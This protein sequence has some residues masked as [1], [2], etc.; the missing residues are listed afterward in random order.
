MITKNSNGKDSSR[1]N[2]IRNTV[3]I[4]AGIAV[5]SLGSTSVL[6]QQSDTIAGSLSDK[7]KKFMALFDLKY[8]I[9]QAPTAGPAG[10]ALA[11]AVANAGAM[12]CLPLS[13]D[14]AEDVLQHV[15]KVKAATKG[16]IF[17]NYVLSFPP[18]TLDKALEAGT[19]IVQFSWGMP[20]KEL[21]SKVHT[22]GAKMGIQVTGKGSAEAAIAL[23]ADYLVCQ[24]TEA[25]GHVQ[26]TKNLESALKEVLKVAGKIPVLVSGGISNGHQ[27]RHWLSK[28]AAGVVM[29]TRFVA[30]KESLAHADYKAAIVEAG[31]DATVL[32]ACFY[33]SGFKNRSALHRVIRNDTFNMWEAAGCPPEG[34]RPGEKDIVAKFISGNDIERYSDYPPV[35][36]MEGKVK[37]LAMYAGQGAANIK[38]IPSVNDLILRLWKEFEKK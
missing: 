8:P 15:S 26:A 10:E 2:F 28:G 22:A 13:W 37:D 3:A 5:G 11:I 7:T 34:Q 24:G 14:S 38:D 30:T 36:S 23:S 31:D 33:K 21:V 25:G 12:G 16:S 4:G 9:V 1:R 19:S 32:S 29:G 35:Q 17:V 18:D 20:G 6:A 27:I